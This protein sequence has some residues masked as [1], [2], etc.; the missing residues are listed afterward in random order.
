MIL[1]ILLLAYILLYVKGLFALLYDNGEFSVVPM[2]KRS[3][4]THP[5]MKYAIPFFA[6]IITLILCV[7]T[8]FT[9]VYSFF[10][11]MTQKK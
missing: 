3:Q 1:N 10:K 2:I 7:V 4:E 9:E 6:L 5:N 11:D 8:P